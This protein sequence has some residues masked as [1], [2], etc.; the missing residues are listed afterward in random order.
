MDEGIF[1]ILKGII[2]TEVLTNAAREWGIFDGPRAWIKGRLDFGR[3][4]LGCFECTS[5]WCGFF[6]VLYLS[7]L[8]IWPLSFA[9]IFHRLA[10][11][12][13]VGFQNLDWRRANQEEDFMRKVS[14]RRE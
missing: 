1:F 13:K 11:F 7:Y 10:C 6:V 4:L 2:L 5:V 3:R 12:L 8:E 9:L 14:G